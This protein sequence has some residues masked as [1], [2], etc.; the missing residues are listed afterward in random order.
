MVPSRSTAP[1]S[2]IPSPVHPPITEEYEKTHGSH[3]GVRL[4]T[5]SEEVLGLR[6]TARNMRAS[7]MICA[8][9]DIVLRSAYIII[10]KVAIYE[11]CRT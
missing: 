5:V 11:T 2:V 7:K 8:S 4:T 3:K 6:S 10:G 1:G 9:D